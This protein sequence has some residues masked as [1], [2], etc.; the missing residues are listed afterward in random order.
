MMEV[1]LQE[2]ATPPSQPYFHLDHH[3]PEM[4]SILLGSN[5]G[6]TVLGLL[7]DLMESPWQKSLQSF[8]ESLLGT[9]GLRYTAQAA[10]TP[11]AAG[12]WE[13]WIEFLPVTGDAPPLRTARETTQPNR[14]DAVYWASGLTTV[15]LEGALERAL[16]PLRQHYAVAPETLF[17]E[18]APARVRAKV[19]DKEE[20]PEVEAAMDPFEV[21]RNGED[22]LRRR[23]TAF[24]AWHLVNIILKYRLSESASSVLELLPASDLID[25]IVG[26]VRERSVRR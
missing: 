12:Q 2:R 8:S 18:P 14:A 6:Y 9:D 26:G 23:L 15:Y 17:D 10:G 20:A 21:Y 3:S 24:E 22:V 16:K 25:I 13:G 4:A 19:P 7:T 11:N 1:P 5:G